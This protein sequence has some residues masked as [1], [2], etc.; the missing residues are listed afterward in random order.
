MWNWGSSAAIRGPG[1]TELALAGV[2]FLGFDSSSAKPHAVNE[3]TAAKP[4]KSA[5]LIRQARWPGRSS[6]D[7][8]CRSEVRISREQGGF[9]TAAHIEISR[10]VE[11]YMVRISSQR[12]GPRA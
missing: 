7:F 12:S 10:V 5:D 3:M 2:S 1:Q 8:P 9:F 4:N 6:V 11:M